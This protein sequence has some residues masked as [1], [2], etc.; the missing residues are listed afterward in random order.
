MRER[1]RDLGG[2]LEKRSEK[3]RTQVSVTLP[4]PSMA[5]AQ[6]A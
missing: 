4:V 3:N 1:V 5:N 2:T 6:S